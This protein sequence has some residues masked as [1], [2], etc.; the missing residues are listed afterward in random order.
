[1]K[2][3]CLLLMLVLGL[4]GPGRPAAAQNALPPLIDR[5]LLFGDPEISGGQLSP[6]GRFLSFI[7]PYNGTRNIWVKGLKEP[8]ASARPMTND[9]A[10]PVR[11]YFW[12]RDDKYL[13]YAQ[14][15]GGDENFNIYAVDPAAA[16]PA[17]QAV[18]PARDLTGLK[19]VRV[20]IYNTQT[21]GEL[22][23]HMVQLARQAGIPRVGVT[24]T[25]PVGMDYARW[26]TSTLQALGTALSGVQP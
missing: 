11:D 8:F 2:K 9:Q 13:L 5:E 18:P 14:D 23:R 15:K 10:R 25:E 24:E 26:M 1:M 19:G 16:L 6:D 4:A 17:G 22:V 3:L 21:D 12:S 7:K 20:L